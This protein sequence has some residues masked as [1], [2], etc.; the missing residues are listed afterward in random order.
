MD[1]FLFLL[2]FPSS[3][4]RGLLM[5]RVR[6]EMQTDGTGAASQPKR[7]AECVLETGGSRA[8][9]V[10]RKLQRNLVS[11]NWWRSGSWS[12]VEWAKR[13]ALELV[14]ETPGPVTQEC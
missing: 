6:P 8:F 14:G 9:V 13:A 1:D 2:P 5:G 10:T 11:S 4:H 12:V 3:T 7:S